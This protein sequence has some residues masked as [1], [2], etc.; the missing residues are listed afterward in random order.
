MLVFSCQENGFSCC[1][2]LDTDK[3]RTVIN[4]DDSCLRNERLHTIFKVEGVVAVLV[5]IT[6]C[7]HSV[8]LFIFN[9]SVTI[10]ADSPVN[11]ISVNWFN[12]WVVAT[13]W[14]VFLKNNQRLSSISV[15]T[16]DCWQDVLPFIAWSPPLELI[17]AIFS[18]LSHNMICFYALVTVHPDGIPLFPVPH[19]D[20]DGFLTNVPVAATPLSQLYVQFVAD[21]FVA[22][23]L[24]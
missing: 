17:K 14:T 22:R 10:M 9:I 18:I 3:A 7:Y 13:C 23:H 2:G 8:Y 20:M 1:C 24:M 5:R 15:H 19:E 21:M 12:W 16:Q 11:H 6:C 4:E